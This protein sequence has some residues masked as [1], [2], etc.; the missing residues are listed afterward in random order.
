MG[1]SMVAPTRAVGSG[2]EQ[3]PGQDQGWNP[4]AACRIRFVNR[5]GA[6]ESGAARLGE[7]F[8]GR[9][10]APAVLPH[11]LL[12]PRTPCHPGQRQARTLGPELGQPLQRRL[13]PT[14]G[15]LHAHRNGAL[16]ACACPAMN[17]VG[18][19]CAG[20]PHA[21]LDWGRLDENPNTR[22]TPAAYLT[23]DVTPSA[24]ECPTPGRR[25]CAS[26]WP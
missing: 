10:L 8:P 7:L 2:H 9:E 21:R 26:N 13:V 5:R 14:P 25:T 24:L 17:G 18:E 11:R 6:P 15:R 23:G 16:W 4:A 1:G 19:P 22:S 12:R 20:E 3:H